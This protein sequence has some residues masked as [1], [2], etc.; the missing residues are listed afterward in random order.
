MPTACAVARMGSAGSTEGT[1]VA[2]AQ[3]P[4]AAGGGGGGGA[5]EA[6]PGWSQRGC[7]A[8]GHAS[9]AGEQ[10]LALT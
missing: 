8:G 3:L 2:A 6:A 10:G 5:G 9:L 1:G 4:A 7:A